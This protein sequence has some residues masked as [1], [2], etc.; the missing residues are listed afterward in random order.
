MRLPRRRRTDAVGL[1]G[2]HLEP[3]EVTLARLDREARQHVA[4]LGL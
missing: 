3:F 4:K 2:P 1:P